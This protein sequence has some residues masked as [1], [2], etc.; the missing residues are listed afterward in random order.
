MDF[1]CV[2]LRWGRVFLLD[3]AQVQS[4]TL[5][6]PAWCDWEVVRAGGVR[7]RG[8]GKRGRFSVACWGCV[9][10]ASEIDHRPPITQ[11]AILIAIFV[12][13]HAPAKIMAGQV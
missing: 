8:M 10:G 9:Q 12:S 5:A 7:K 3:K 13:C 4:L 11:R 6:A 2:P 1:F